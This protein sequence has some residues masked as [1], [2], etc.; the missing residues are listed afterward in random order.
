MGCCSSA[1]DEEGNEACIFNIARSD[2]IR[3]IRLHRATRAINQ[4]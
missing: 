2:L 4:W 3:S 1:P